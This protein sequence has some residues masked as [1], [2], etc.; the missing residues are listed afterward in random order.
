MSKSGFHACTRCGR[1][2]SKRYTLCFECDHRQKDA[3]AYQEYLKKTPEERDIE[4]EIY[5]SHECS[6]CGKEGADWH[7]D[8]LFCGSCWAVRSS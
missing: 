7:G 2:I 4:R 8:K 6:M 1:G 3:V 5:Y